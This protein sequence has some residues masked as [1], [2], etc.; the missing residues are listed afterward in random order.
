M[1]QCEDFAGSEKI[2][3]WNLFS[4]WVKTFFFTRYPA[5]EQDGFFVF[6]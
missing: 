4:G 6:F 2:R 1:L 3:A 5:G